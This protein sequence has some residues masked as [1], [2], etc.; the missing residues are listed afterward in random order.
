MNDSI[1]SEGLWTSLLVFTVL[2]KIPGRDNQFPNQATS[3]RS[4]AD[5]RREMEIIS[6]E[7]WVSHAIRSKVPTSSSVDI[8]IGSLVLVFRENEECWTGTF[9]V[10]NI[11][12]KDV[13]TEKQY[14]KARHFNIVNV[15][16][17]IEDQD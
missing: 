10:I 5:E 2:S 1:C 17:Y 15:N 4:L 3:M 8:H 7:L 16:P 9:P 6:T 13:T 14:G 12:E 11:T